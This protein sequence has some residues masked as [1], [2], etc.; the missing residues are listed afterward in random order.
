MRTI[1]LSGCLSLSLSALAN[2]SFLYTLTEA[3]SDVVGT[4]SGTLDIVDL[5]SPITASNCNAGF[6]AS[7]GLAS[8]GASTGTCTGLFAITGPTSIGF[9]SQIERANT[10]TGDIAA[11]W[12]DVQELFVPIGYVSGTSL[13]NSETFDSET[14]ASLGLT[15]GTY[16]WTWGTG[17]DADSFTVQIGSA[18]PEPG[19]L[20]LLC[21]G[22]CALLRVRRAGL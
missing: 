14:F 7:V 17:Q 19:T 9:E 16:T 11:V 13:S 1:L 12:G 2:A 20:T 15:P 10:A 5:G 6:N 8:G 18:A 22:A 21:L 4:G 3:G